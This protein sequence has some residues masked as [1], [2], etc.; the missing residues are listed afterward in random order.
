M[1]TINFGSKYTS[2]ID[3]ITEV[4][5]LT[6]SC[7]FDVNYET[8]TI[9]VK[10][11]DPF[12]SRMDEFN[13]Y[14][15]F[16]YAG[17][18]EFNGSTD[19]DAPQ[20]TSANFQ[21]LVVATKANIDSI[22][23]DSVLNSTDDLAEGST[24]KYFSESSRLDVEANTSARHTHDQDLSIGASPVFNGE[25][26]T[27]LP[28]GGDMFKGTYDPLNRQLNVYSRSNH[29][30]TQLADTISDFDL[31]VRENSDVSA[32]ISAR[33]NHGNKGFLDNINQELGQGSS[34]VFNAENFMNM[35]DSLL[36]SVYD[37]ASINSNVFDRANHIGQQDASTISNFDLEVSN[38]DDV[39]SNS[40]NRHSHL[41]KNFLDLLD[42]DVSAGS[43]PF[44]SAE[45]FTNFPSGTGDMIASTYDPNSIS[46]DV[47]E[48]SNHIGT[49]QSNTISDFQDSVSVN[50]DVASNTLSRHTH[51]NLV[52]LDSIDQDLGSG[53]SPVF[54]G[55]N[56]SDLPSINEL[57][58]VDITSGS[59][60]DI[61]VKSASGSVETVKNPNT[62]DISAQNISRLESS[63]SWDESG[64]IGDPITDTYA[65]Q[66]HYD[67]DYF[68]YATSDNIWQ[69]VKKDRP[70]KTSSG[71]SLD[72]SSR[73]GSFY[74]QTT[75]ASDSSYTLGAGSVD[76]GY[77]L[78]RHN[79]ASPPTFSPS[80]IDL[81]VEDNYQPNQD[82]I[83]VV[84]SFDVSQGKY[85]VNWNGND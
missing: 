62:Y 61:L 38:N 79:A 67:E 18:D 15:I 31:A 4:T 30:G 66:S 41:N 58:D 19:P 11:F 28:G 85:Y 69:R 50:T 44:L 36:K 55:S 2:V 68:Y 76:G 47:F 22:F 56:F 21:K 5:L 34:P 65:G 73:S 71:S 1:Q 14:G 17:I 42:Q 3:S 52:N 51:T 46:G 35:P 10:G 72:L 75:A 63:S 37:P 7:T 13:L 57:S 49:Q 20:G 45:N 78:I 43:A 24:N 8:E 82:N 29:S 59:E 26:F 23:A 9:V 54:S 74:G 48:R 6:V 84:W 53:S 64:Y 25:N 83:L 16:D 70:P 39:S 77:A 81:G 32:N 60:G 33:H 27:N 40:L 12:Y 80:I